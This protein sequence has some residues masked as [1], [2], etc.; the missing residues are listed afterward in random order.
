MCYLWPAPCCYVADSPLR[1]IFMTSPC[2]MNYGNASLHLT[3]S[4]CNLSEGAS[5]EIKVNIFPFFPTTVILYLLEL[6]E[7]VKQLHEN[8]HSTLIL[9][10]MEF[11]KYVL[12]LS[13]ALTDMGETGTQSQNSFCRTWR[14]LTHH[15][16]TH[17]YCQL[18]GVSKGGEKHLPFIL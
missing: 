8:E 5:L 3:W 9:D 17:S 4:W 1:F 2:H 13:S 16:S 15:T 10:F 14:P 18:V 6:S 12:P 11:M 7:K